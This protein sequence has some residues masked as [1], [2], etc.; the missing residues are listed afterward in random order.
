MQPG[1]EQVLSA[2]AERTLDARSDVYS[3]GAVSDE[4]IAGEPPSLPMLRRAGAEPGK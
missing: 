2:S 4:M 1:P 3:L